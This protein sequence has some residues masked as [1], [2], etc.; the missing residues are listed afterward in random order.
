M[1]PVLRSMSGGSRSRPVTARISLLGVWTA[2]AMTTVR[3]LNSDE[4]AMARGSGPRAPARTNSPDQ[5][6]E[7]A[8]AALALHLDPPGLNP[9]IGHDPSSNPTNRSSV[10]Q[11]DAE[12]L[13]RRERV[14]RR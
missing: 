8:V 14:P 11:L 9:R 10:S 5:D 3:A 6:A 1:A 4:C 12:P 13:E 2:P 7:T